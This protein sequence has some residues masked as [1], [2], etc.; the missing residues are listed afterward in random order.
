[1]SHAHM[2]ASR[3]GQLRAQALE[4][5]GCSRTGE[6]GEDGKFLVK[7]MECLGVCEIAPAVWIDGEVH[8]E[9]TS[10][11]LDELMDGCA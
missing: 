7:D 1:M 10:E 2:L 5:A 8:T 11:R 6:V 4:K 9:V 3:C